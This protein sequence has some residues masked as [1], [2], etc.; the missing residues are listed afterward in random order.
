MKLRR[1][2]LIQSCLGEERFCHSTSYYM[3]IRRRKRD[4]DRHDINKMKGYTLL[5]EGIDEMVGI[6]Y[7]P[8]TKETR[9]TYEVLLSFIQAALGDQPRDILC[10]AADEVLAVLKNE[11]LRDKERRKEIDL[12]LGQTDDTRYHVLVN[13]GKKITDYGGDKEIQNM[14]DNIDETYGVN[15]QFESDE[16][17]SDKANGPSPFLFLKLFEVKGP[18]LV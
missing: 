15:V 2:D 5:S 1:V 8:K 4:E 18:L 7:K 12:L 3:S 9:E 16:E 6:I 11:K 17:V 14:D 10:G 13:L